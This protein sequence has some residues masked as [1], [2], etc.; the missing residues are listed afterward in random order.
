VDLSVTETLAPQVPAGVAKVAESGIR[1]PEEVRRLAACG[2]DAMLVGEALMRAG[3]VEEA[4][5]HL[6]EAGCRG[7]P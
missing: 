7:S 2:V 3:D 5:R 6:V 1:G 4:A